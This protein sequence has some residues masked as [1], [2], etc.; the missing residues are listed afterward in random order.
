LFINRN[1]APDGALFFGRMLKKISNAIVCIDIVLIPAY[2]LLECFEMVPTADITTAE[3]I[4]FYTMMICVLYN[5]CSI[6]QRRKMDTLELI[7]FIYVGYMVVNVCCAQDSLL[8]LEGNSFSY[9]GFW[10]NCAYLAMMN[11]VWKSEW[12]YE[13]YYYGAFSALGII[14]ALI[15][16]TQAIV[17]LENLMEQVL[18]IQMN[19]TRAFGTLQNPNPYGALM[20]MLAAIEWCKIKKSVKEKRSAHILMFSLYSCAL[21]LSGTRAAVVGLGCAIIIEA[22][23]DRHS[24][25]KNYRKEQTHIYGVL[26]GCFTVLL[27]ISFGFSNV[28][29]DLVERIQS[30]FLNASGFTALGSGRIDIWKRTWDVFWKHPI[31][32]VG[33]ANLKLVKFLENGDMSIA[34]VAHNEYLNILA[35]QGILGLIIY[36]TMIVTAFKSVKNHGNQSCPY[37]IAVI[38][39]L[40]TDFFGWRIIYLTPYFYIMIG[41]MNDK[42]KGENEYVQIQENRQQGN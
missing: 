15:G 10:M 5:I 42:T 39:C 38:T 16:F 7:S 1:S 14:E 11:T 26:L 41:L 3:I 37:I 32:G 9:E 6:I 23:L 40:I 17:P 36:G 2:F 18:N 22:I 35:T 13:K 8:A 20:A 34:Y 21:L 28:G 4:L 27:L 33:V 25:G 30:D 24:L 12:R 19:S 29:K 31:V